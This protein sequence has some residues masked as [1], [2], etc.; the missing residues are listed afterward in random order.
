[1]E[2]NSITATKHPVAL[3][4]ALYV[5]NGR[6]PTHEQESGCCIRLG[7]AAEQESEKT[8]CTLTLQIDDCSIPHSRYVANV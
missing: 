3:S 5:L 1:M 8:D 2:L 4:L 6:V 7:M